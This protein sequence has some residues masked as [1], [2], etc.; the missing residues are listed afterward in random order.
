MTRS[1]R[2]RRASSAWRSAPC[3][4][5]TGR[6]PSRSTLWADTALA[7]AADA[8]PGAG[9]RV[10]DAADS[11]QIV[12]CMSWP[13]DDPSTASP[14]RSA[15]TPRHRLYSG[16]GGTTPQVLVQDAARAILA[17]E[18]DVA[19]ITGAE[20]LDTK[21][22]AKK[23]GERLAWS[24]RAEKPDP[25]P[26]EAP[27][28]PAEIAHEVFQAWLTFPVFDVARRARLGIAPADYAA[29]IG[30]LLAPF[31]EVAA[32]EPVRLVPRRAHRRGAVD[33]D[34]PTTAWSATRTRSGPC[35]SWTSTWPPR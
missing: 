32:D 20:A 13:Y 33:A 31:S 12:Y 26:F 17:G 34:A 22:R 24:H 2:G 10:L 4:P 19:V 6:A 16:I 30:E 5:R 11:L 7:A 8:L 27:F 14:T 29:A 15:S 25:F 1:T 9:Q 28:H 18:V 23:A 21:R 3:G 35:R